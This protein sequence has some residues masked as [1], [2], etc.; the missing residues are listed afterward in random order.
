MS[1]DPRFL[2]PAPVPERPCAGSDAALA[3]RS[4]GRGLC[5]APVPERGRKTYG[6]AVF[7]SKNEVS[8]VS[9]VTLPA[10]VGGRCR[11]VSIF[12]AGVGRA[13]REPDLSARRP[14]AGAANAGKF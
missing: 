2:G 5:A 7:E 10:T 12:S 8:G 13:S 4:S 3:E 14:D 11:T 6:A 1:A 9:G